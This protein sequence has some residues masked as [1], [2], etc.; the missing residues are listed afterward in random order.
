MLTPPSILARTLSPNLHSSSSTTSLNTNGILPDLPVE[1]Q[2]NIIQLSLST[3]ISDITSV[4]DTINLDIVIPRLALQEQRSFHTHALN[5]A[6][7]S[8]EYLTFVVI[9]AEVRS[10]ALYEVYWTEL[11]SRPF[12][13]C[14]HFWP[15][16][17]KGYITPG[18]FCCRYMTLSKIRADNEQLCYELRQMKQDWEAAVMYGKWRRFE[19]GKA[20]ILRMVKSLFCFADDGYEMLR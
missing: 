18:C 20:R 2:Q 6:H 5:L 8:E 11:E 9:I 15:W 17:H 16:S 1:V 13:Q 19:D 7:V 14:R 12:H 10:R 4:I 3:D